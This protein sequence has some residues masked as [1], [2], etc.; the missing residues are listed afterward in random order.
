MGCFVLLLLPQGG[1][2][3]VSKAAASSREK[4]SGAGVSVG[5]QQGDLASV[6]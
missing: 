1:W 6:G 3:S 4:L 5:G 2:S